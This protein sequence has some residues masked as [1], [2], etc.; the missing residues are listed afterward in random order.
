MDGARR[1][2]NRCWRLVVGGRF[3]FRVPCSELQERTK[4]NHE[5]AKERKHEKKENSTPFVSFSF[6]AFVVQTR[7]LAPFCAV[8][9]GE[10]EAAELRSAAAVEEVASLG[11]PRVLP[12]IPDAAGIFKKIQDR[13]HFKRRPLFVI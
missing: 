4:A 8:G 12:H 2:G 5:D 6:R 11:D 1:T 7:V 13:P 9:G 3:Q 10:S